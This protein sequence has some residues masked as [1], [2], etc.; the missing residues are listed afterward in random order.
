MPARSL[1]CAR[2]R[3]ARRRGGSL[4][5][6][7]ALAV[8][9]FLL[10]SAV[11][12]KGSGDAPAEVITRPFLWRIEFPDRP[13]SWIFGTIHLSRPGLAA[14]NPA[15]DAA[16]DA[17]DAVFTEIPNDPT[18]LLSVAPR[19]LLPRGQSLKD[20]LPP[21]VL[22]DFRSELAHIAP[23]LPAEPFLKFKPWALC[24]SLVMLGDQRRH[25]DQ[26]G[27]DT[28][29]FQRAVQAGKSAAGLETIEDQLGIFDELTT[30][31]QVALLRDTIRQLREFRR[32]GES[33]TDLLVRLYLAGDL[34]GLAR[35]LERWNEL[36]DDPALTARFNERILYGRNA[37]LAEAMLAQMHAKPA[38]SCFFAVGAAHL[39]GPRGILAALEKAGCTLTRVK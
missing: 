11:G 2:G 25:P 19:M 7:L 27:M 39:P 5:I 14:L 31:E 10:P 6:A 26:M 8:V 9:G 37:T 22:A 4:A 15:I 16:M 24:V 1:A 35:E 13:P 12:A 20:Q 30:G 23:G 29:I 34:D 21:A 3:V 33:P 18:T 38:R 17:A 32:I 28:I 36:G